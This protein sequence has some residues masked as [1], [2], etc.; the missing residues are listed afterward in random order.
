MKVAQLN[1]RHS[2]MVG[3]LVLHFLQDSTISIMLVQ[4]PPRPWL[5]KDTIGSFNLFKPTG[6]D[7]LS[8][9]L[10]KHNIQASLVP[11][12][13]ARVCVVVVGKGHDTIFFISGYVQ[14]IT[15][16]GCAEI[17]RALRAV[18]SV[19]HKCL[20]MDGNGHSP[21]WGPSDVDTN[22]QGVLLE[23]LM[24]SEEIFPINVPESSPTYIGDDGRQS[25]IDIS[26][27]SAGLLGKVCNWTVV[28]DAGLGSDHALLTWELRL[29]SPPALQ[30]HRLN[31]KTVNWTQFQH[32]LRETMRSV[33]NF[34]LD[35]PEQLDI[36]VAGFTE[37]LQQ[38]VTNHVPVKRVCQ[39]SRN[40]WT[41]DIKIL[42]ERMR[43]AARHWQK[44]RIL[45][46]RANYLHARQ[47]LR[48]AIRRSKRLQ[49]RMWCASFTR[50]NPWQLLRFVK[51]R[52]S[53]SVEALSVDGSLIQDDVGKAQHLK[54]IF[55][56]TLPRAN[57]RF[58]T[59]IDFKWSTARP[60]GQLSDT[61]VTTREL[62]AA[63]GRMRR[64]AATGPDQLPILLIERCFRELS[65]FLCRLFT[66]SLQL[67]FF[68]SQW[69]SAKVIALRKP[70]KASYA[71][72]RAYR[73]ISLLN[74]CAKLL[75][76][77][78]N[79]RL[80]NWAEQH[81]VFSKFQWGF[82]P[83]RH[84]QGACWRLVEVITSALR[85]RDQI[86]AVAL[87]IQ[88]AYDSV[89]QHGLLEKMQRK[90]IPSYLIHWTHSFIA[91]RCCRIHVGESEV[92]CTP[93]CGL[94][95]GS[96]L[97]PT[98]FLLFIDDLLVELIK[99]GVDCQAFADDVLV[100]I[101]GNFRQGM[102]SPFLTTAM[103][104]VDDWARRW[105]LTFN[106][107]KCAAIC[108]AG[109]RVQIQ[110]QFQVSLRSGPIPTVQALRYLGI[111]FDQHI[112]WHRQVRETTASA[113]RLLWSLKQIVGST[114]GASPEVMLRLIQQ[115]VL[116]KLFFGV[117]CWSTVIRSERF[118]RSLDQ[119]LSTS[120][121][122][123]LGL[124]RFTATET[125][126]V[127]ANIQPANL[128]ILRRLCRFMIKN[129]RIDLVTPRQVD[130][131]GTFLLPREIGTAWFH[132]IVL[133]RGLLANPPPSR[134]HLLTSAIDRGLL[135]EW[136]ARWRAAP[137][138]QDVRKIFP[139]AGSVNVSMRGRD[140]D[141]LT[142][143]LR[144]LVSDV[145]MGTLHLPRDDEFDTLCPLCGDDLT[146][147]HLLC[148]CKG[149]AME[150]QHFLQRIPERYLSDLQWLSRFGE[151]PLSN[152]LHSIQQRFATVG[153]MGIRS[154]EIQNIS[155]KE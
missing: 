121:R 139:L 112:L 38:M 111:W 149:L 50:A 126:L 118:L 127:V 106:P 4:D 63:V 91:Q 51:P 56:P 146:R 76:T 27:V 131:P 1:M 19:H 18:G 138:V 14:P 28:A 147:L 87:D 65:P 151:R 135:Q 114:W 86:Q 101:Q 97:S 116:P 123:A 62:R 2:P 144:F 104:T 26:A 33:N 10:V 107:A 16:V 46:F 82:R 3:E 31:W 155:S 89:W 125:A 108:F 47:L 81:R 148:E 141:K 60:P 54:K 140:R 93:E 133:S 94:P 99:T 22:P 53:Q 85:S 128:Q 57:L 43:Q 100:W 69:K 71:D 70:G 59:S 74:H 9:I 129:Y 153:N 88:A 95:Q 21:V 58:H 66:A 29:R 17:G 102:T 8:I 145:Y 77:V 30:K 39:F 73:P 20:G 90:K 41:P 15:G 61:K 24:A 72:P 83:G 7:S 78:V 84:V 5:M 110:Q 92:V 117:E 52:S 96:P 13:A 130:V 120:A 48:T 105:R 119:V 80:K 113:K 142:R 68:P 6:V 103:A 143:F 25:W 152:F 136:N 124:D 137:E 32:R 12:G 75:E 115:V 34:Q 132:R 49:W 44:K 154:S 67:G 40:W 64:K 11:V 122:M 23:N 45:H 150:R 134:P 35:S 79:V 55:F 37:M 42:H 36:A 109:P 98:L